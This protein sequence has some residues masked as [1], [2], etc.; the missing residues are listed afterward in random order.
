MFFNIE[1]YQRHMTPEDLL[2]VEPEV[3][4]KLILHKRERIAQKLPELISNTG[5]EKLTAENFAR[6]ARSIK[7]DIEPKVDNLFAERGA[8]AEECSKISDYTNLNTKAK[9]RLN[10][11]IDNIKSKQIELENYNSA[12]EEIVELI[13]KSG[14][15]VSLLTAIDTSRKANQALKEIINEYETAKKNWNECETNRRRLESKYAKLLSNLKEANIAK[16]YWQE[17]L[18]LGFEDLLIDANRVANGGLSSRQ[19]IR[20]KKEINKS[21]RI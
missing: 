17:K 11:L 20:N 8:I 6:Q 15:D 14:H 13:T 7:E 3:L 1:F 10:E 16:N 21:R 2:R 9:K 4:A 18:D 19:I 12:C 5:D